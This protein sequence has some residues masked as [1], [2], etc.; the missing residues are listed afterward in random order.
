[1]KRNSSLFFVWFFNL[2]LFQLFCTFPFHWTPTLPFQERCGWRLHNICF[3]VDLLL[4]HP[5][6]GYPLFL[7]WKE[8]KKKKKIC[9]TTVLQTICW[10]KKNILEKWLPALN[11]HKGLICRLTKCLNPFI[12]CKIYF[13]MPYLEKN[14]SQYFKKCFCLYFI[15]DF[16]ILLIVI[17]SV[18]IKVTH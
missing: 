5:Y 17:K 15:L 18:F 3:T 12:L 14:N 16:K 2:E 4:R 7:D 8:G 10:R 1:M 9:T 11:D 13:S 6:R